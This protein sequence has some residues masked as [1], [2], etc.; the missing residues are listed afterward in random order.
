MR[1]PLSS[2]DIDEA[3]IQAVTG[4]LRTPRLSIG[5]KME[6]FE[7]AVAAYTGV[8]Y[9][10]ALSS[11]TAGLHLGL[12]ALGI[13]E[14]DEV[15]LPSF[16]FIAAAH[17]V[18]YRRARPVFVDIDPLTLNLTAET[19]APAITPRTRAI[20][21]VHT[22]GCPVDM[23]P[24]LDLAARHGVKVIEDA[25]EALGADC[26]G[27]KVGGLGDLG[28]FAFYPN[29]PITT[30]EG[31]MVVTSDRQL[32]DAIRALRN[33]GRRASDGWLDHS[34]LGYNYRLSEMNCALGVSQMRR[35][36]EMLARRESRAACYME[37]LRGIPDLTLP[38]FKTNHGR[39]CWFV[40]VVRLGASRT[41]DDRDGVM[42]F[43]TARGIGCGSYFAPVH[44]Q[45][46][47]AG[48]A[49]GG[50][51]LTVTDRVAPRTLALPFFNRITDDEI[52]EV[53]SALHEAITTAAGHKEG[54]LPNFSGEAVPKRSR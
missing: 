32:A 44:G 28:V 11:G 40:F 5:P 31:G 18:L 42:D 34:L 45:P 54:S 35:I 1:I 30:G 2:P 48:Y 10:V 17:A 20:I 22:F 25:C 23:E 51:D 7:E 4:V 47:Y 26:G 50:H 38:V 39:V 41:R 14:G 15:I 6:E 52:A 49:D 33:Q 8:P 24:V 3:D 46:L 13:G 53:C 12:T 21:A 36:E 27:R 9:G 19:V 16:T 43:M 37:H 29:K